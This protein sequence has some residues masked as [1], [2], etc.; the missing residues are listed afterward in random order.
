M[1]RSRTVS[2]RRAGVWPWPC[3]WRSALRSHRSPD[4]SRATE[5]SSRH[6]RATS[7][8]VAEPPVH[9]PNADT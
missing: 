2:W 8:T 3:V 6:T 1:R 4:G 9:V 5:N 7:A